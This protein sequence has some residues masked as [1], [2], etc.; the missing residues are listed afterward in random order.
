MTKDDDI[1]STCMWNYGEEQQIHSQKSHDEG[2]KGGF[3]ESHYFSF[4]FTFCF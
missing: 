1:F 4:G 2:F 3:I